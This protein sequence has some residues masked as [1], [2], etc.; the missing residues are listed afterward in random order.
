MDKNI[1]QVNGGITINVYV[2]VKK[3]NIWEKDYIWNPA[4]YS[5]QNGKCLASIMD[6]SPIMCDE[7]IE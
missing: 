4:T 2:S 3:R 1:I 6:N 5:C 7:V